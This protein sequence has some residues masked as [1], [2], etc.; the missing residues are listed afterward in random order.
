MFHEL[1]IKWE[2]ISTITD[3]AYELPYQFM[4]DLRLGILGN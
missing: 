4:K 1:Q 2:L 3:T